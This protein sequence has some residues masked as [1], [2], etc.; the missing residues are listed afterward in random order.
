[1]KREG[2]VDKLSLTTTKRGLEKMLAMLK[3]LR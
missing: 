3:V 1:M 2:G